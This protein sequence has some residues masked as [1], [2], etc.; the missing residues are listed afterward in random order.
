TIPMGFVSS[1][2]S[3]RA[4]G[5]GA[6]G[7]ANRQAGVIGTGRIQLPRNQYACGRKFRSDAVLLDYVPEVRN[8]LYVRAESVRQL[9]LLEALKTRSHE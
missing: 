6:L 2:I 5:R 9:S 1:M 8:R 7:A 4:S 3:A